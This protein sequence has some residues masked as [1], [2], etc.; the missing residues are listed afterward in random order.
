[1]KTEVEPRPGTKAAIQ[2]ELR[3]A[4]ADL[5]R[6]ADAIYAE[7]NKRGWC[8]EYEVFVRFHNKRLST[9]RL[10]VRSVDFPAVTEI[11]NDCNCASCR[12]ARAELE[13]RRR[14]D[15]L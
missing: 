7:A 8:S 5:A 11:V 14:R 4:L 1:M 12:E 2:E 6:I 3:A 15:L 13:E 10:R 9:P